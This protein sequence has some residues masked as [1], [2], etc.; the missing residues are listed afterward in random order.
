MAAPFSSRLLPFGKLD[1][2]WSRRERDPIVDN[3]AFSINHV[4]ELRTILQA[5]NSLRVTPRVERNS[6]RFSVPIESSDDG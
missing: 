3:G 6:F 2:I 4:D 5:S 1:L